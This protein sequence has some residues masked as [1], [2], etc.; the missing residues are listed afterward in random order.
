M[1]SVKARTSRENKPM[2]V[3]FKT[4]FISI[5]GVLQL[6]KYYLFIWEAIYVWCRCYSDP[7]AGQWY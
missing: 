5:G 7:Y 3:Y 4:F 2:P 1:G 6:E